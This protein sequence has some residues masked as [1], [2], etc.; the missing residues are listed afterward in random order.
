[1]NPAVE[2]N[3]V[4]ERLAGLPLAEVRFSAETGSTNDDAQSW[5]ETGAGDASLV[6]ADRQTAGRGRL[7]RRWITQPGAALAFSLILHPSPAEME[8]LALFSPL[9]GLA[10]C[11]GLAACCGLKAEIK[12][13]NDVLLGR[14]KVCGVLAE[15][16][17]QADRLAGVVIGIGVNVAP[18]A[19][20]PADELLF[21]ATCVED[22]LGRPVD[23]WAL[24]AAILRAAFSWRRMLG[25]AEFFRGWQG[26]LAF[27]GEAVR[28]GTPESVIR[29]T[30]IGID[31][32][33]G[34]VLRTAAGKQEVITVGDVSL[35]P[36]E[37]S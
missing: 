19:V 13:P 27:K 33:G 20:P 37:A 15:T 8:T 36:A 4:R 1:M 3:M 16:S 32:Q 34:L 24:L 12:W 23:R 31:P 25:S 29:G 5:L 21:P 26:R 28:V 14:R 22:A 7:N 17:W 11:D 18:S 9:A 2:E 6:V 30:L 35:R 10:V